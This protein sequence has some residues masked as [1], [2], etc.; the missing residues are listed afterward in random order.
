MW[1]QQE[2]GAKL[3]ALVPN[4]QISLPRPPTLLCVLYGTLQNS[5]FEE[6]IRGFEKV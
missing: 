2:D 6:R 5:M 3:L 4:Q 1:K